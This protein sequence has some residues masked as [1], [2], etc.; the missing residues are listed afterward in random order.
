TSAITERILDPERFRP[1]AESF[2]RNQL[3]QI[4][5]VLNRQHGEMKYSSHPSILF[6]IAVMK[7]C[8]SGDMSIP[9]RVEGQAQAGGEATLLEALKQRVSKLEQ[10]VD[11]L[12]SAPSAEASPSSAATAAAGSASFG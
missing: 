9:Q 10:T 3:F 6:E 11:K 5:E 8:S 1:T 12:R 2:N 7:L 4:I